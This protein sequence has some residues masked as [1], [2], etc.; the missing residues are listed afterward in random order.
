MTFAVGAVTWALVGVAVAFG[1]VLT[2]LVTAW[3]MGRL[4]IDLGWGRSLHA[5]GP[6][7]STIEAPREVVFDVLSA[8]Y[9]GRLPSE[10]RGQLE[11]LDRGV[12][13]V[14]AA[15]HTRLRTHTST[16]VESVRFE[17]P[18]RISFRLLRGVSPHVIEEFV[19]EDEDG[20]TRFRYSGELAM[21]F[22]A[23]GKL[24]GRHLVKPIWER[25]VARHVAQVKGAAE[26]RARGR[27]AKRSTG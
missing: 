18:E 15:H 9:L 12:D 21:D 13:L 17:R 5:L 2:L 23:V 16:T 25:V 14:V 4:T 19:L 11:V 24:A 27:H 22:W 1:A 7:E 10:L 3:L 8:P 20:A 6:I 26:E